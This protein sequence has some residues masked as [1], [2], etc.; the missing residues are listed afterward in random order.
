MDQEGV[1]KALSIREPYLDYIIRCGKRIENRS[2]ATSY[3][4]ELV[5]HA[6]LRVEHAGIVAGY[7]DEARRY[8]KTLGMIRG[9]CR[10]TDCLR[11]REALRCFPSQACWIYAGED[12]WCW[13][14]ENVEPFPCPQ[15]AKGRL[16]LWEVDDELVEMAR[17]HL[18]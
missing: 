17:G 8:M 13:V 5:L 15:P 10:I 4:G 2:W 18:S 1:V 16:G 9:Q 7:H 12:S 11:P 14:L 6:S 3:R